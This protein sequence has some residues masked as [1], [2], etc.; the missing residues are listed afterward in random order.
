M[1]SMYY[2]VP[3]KN[4]NLYFVRN[5]VWQTGGGWPGGVAGEGGV[6]EEEEEGRDFN[7]LCVYL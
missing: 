6:Q 3:I 7:F 1:H 5:T 2:A 4:V